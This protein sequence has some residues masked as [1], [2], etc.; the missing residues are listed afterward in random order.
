MQAIKCKPISGDRDD[1]DDP[2]LSQTTAVSPRFHNACASKWRQ[3]KSLQSSTLSFLWKRLKTRVYLYSKLYT[4]PTLLFPENILIPRNDAFFAI[5]LSL[6]L[7]IL[8][9]GQGLLFGF[10]PTEP[11]VR[12]DWDDRGDPPLPAVFI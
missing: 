6:L 4:F 10:S 8:Q 9:Q 5:F 11:R 12:D 7:N 1:R 3:M 2:K